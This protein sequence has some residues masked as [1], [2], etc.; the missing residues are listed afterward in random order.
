MAED[1]KDTKATEKADEKGRDSTAGIGDSIAAQANASGDAETAAKRRAAQ[2]AEPTEETPA[3]FGGS[4]L[5]EDAA[6]GDKAA[7]TAEYFLAL[8]K[9]SDPDLKGLP[10]EDKEPSARIARTDGTIKSSGI[11]G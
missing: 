7:Q 3:K 2:Q 11:S 1:K 8:D 4:D 6:S 9:K 5:D 10:K